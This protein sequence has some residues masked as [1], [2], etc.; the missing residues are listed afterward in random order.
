MR[1]RTA[2]MILGLAAGLTPLAHA[3]VIQVTLSGN[4]TCSNMTTAFPAGQLLT[5]TFTYESSGLPQLISFGQAIYV[6]HV[7]SL[8]VVSGGYS[9]SYSA[10]A[11]GQM[12][13]TAAGMSFEFLR[14]PAGHQFTNPKPHGVQMATVVNSGVKIGRAHV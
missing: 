10:A 8:S 14:N 2:V 5:M 7:L 11:F 13:R 1:M 3:N 6:D 9:S 4:I 12:Y